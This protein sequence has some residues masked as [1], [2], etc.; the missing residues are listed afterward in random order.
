M[1]GNFPVITAIPQ[2]L[3]FSFIAEASSFI[4]EGGVRSESS[5]H[6]LI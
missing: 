2:I 3:E 4:Q 5:A 6:V 1:E